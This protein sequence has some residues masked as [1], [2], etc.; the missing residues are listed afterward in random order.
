[1]FLSSRFLI[2]G[3]LF[4]VIE[5]PAHTQPET[6]PYDIVITGGR[7][8]D[9]SG[10]PA[11]ETDIA[12]RDGRIAA[13]GRLADA[14]AQTVIRADN[15]LVT[16]GFIDV[17]SHAGEGLAADLNHGQPVLAQGITTVV[18]NP[19]GGGPVDVAAQ[20]ATYEKNGIGPNAAFFVPHGSIREQVL[21]MQDRAPTA[22][23]LQQMVN[24]VRAGMKAG[25]VGLSSGPYY[26]PGSYAKTDELVAMSKAAAES[27]GVYSSH[28]RD[29][30]DY[31]I[32]LVAA[33]DEVIT[34]AE[35]AKLP[36]I[37]THMKALGVGTWGKA[38]TAIQHIEAARGRGVHV[39]ADQ[40]P[41]EASGTSIEGAL[42]PRWAQV[43]GDE[44]MIRRAKGDERGKLLEDMKT[45]IARRGGAESLL[46]ARFQPDPTLE[47]KSLDELAKAAG[48][49]AEEVAIDLLVRGG[50][51]L[52]SF[53]MTEND[54]ELIMKQPWTMTSSDGGLGPMGVGRPHPRAY[55][56]F[57]R[58][59][60]LYVRERMVVEWAFAIKSMTSLP[61]TVFGLKDRGVLRPGAWADIVV[62]EPDKVADLATY[63][64]P[65]QLSV[66]IDTIV[67]NG[68]LAR[69]DGKFITPLPGKVVTLER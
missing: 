17:H 4:V 21:G 23:E 41:Y 30:S 58:K 3:L 28:I 44:A 37:V 6:A 48:K 31:T 47:G 5:G 14:R 15:R 34:V 24:L 13:I 36:G 61:A 68:R 53:N 10:G 49:S 52:V 32:G 11:I 12:V 27:G 22:A 66:G 55:G 25:A 46:I 20:R 29:E 40:Y 8:L 16:P 39:Y 33:V 2:V 38:A 42:V 64:E 18:V 51:G 45:N 59:L 56:A 9:G 50:A 65:H 69:L 19:D 1:M 26:A 62:I 43:F 7:V 57:P 35:Q 63:A 67:V 54:I 60:R